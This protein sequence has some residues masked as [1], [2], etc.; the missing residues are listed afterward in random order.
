MEGYRPLCRSRTNKVVC[1]LCGG[2]G[3]YLGVDPNVLR[4]ALV[5]LALVFPPIVVVYLLACL[6]IPA[7]DGEC[8]GSVLG[9]AQPQIRGGEALVALALGLVV[10]IVGLALLA[11]GLFEALG[12]FA[13]LVGWPSWPG[14]A[15][16]AALGILLVVVG[17]L[18]VAISLSRP[19]NEEGAR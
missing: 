17:V 11:H 7:K 2:M 13:R 3:E 14:W 1:G 10:L 4:L 9:G 19:R 12:L 6:L 18:L 16:G 15:L 5:A 8:R